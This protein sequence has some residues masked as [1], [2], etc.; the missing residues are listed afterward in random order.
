MDLAARE[1]EL[2]ALDAQLEAKQRE[3]VR[4]ADAT[5][6][7]QAARLDAI[8]GRGATG[9]DLGLGHQHEE[10]E[11]EQAQEYGDSGYAE[12]E[13]PASA[14]SREEKSDR[15]PPSQRLVP[16]KPARKRPGSR[17]RDGVA[18]ASPKSGDS[19]ENVLRNGNNNN[20]NNSNS[21]SD[22]KIRSTGGRME[23]RE[24]EGPHDDSSGSPREMGPDA[25]IRLQ[26]AKLKVLSDDLKKAEARIK[27]LANDS[28]SHKKKAKETLEENARLKKRVQSLEGSKDKD[29]AESTKLRNRVAELEQQLAT[30]TKELK[31][32][33]RAVKQVENEGNSKDVR[34]NR[35][36]EEIDRLKEKLRDADTAR[37]EDV[38]GSDAELKRIRGETKRLER[39]KAELLA[40]F[41]KQLKLI[42]VLKRQ[43]IHLEAA[44]ML[45]FTEEE[46]SRTLAAHQ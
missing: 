45:S 7:A 10:R 42:D 16:G 20:N 25:V 3:A 38:D 21:S 29:R 32:T 46:F 41:K 15:S 36:L 23:G 19:G 12:D 22:G 26:R 17:R 27:V 11:R 6:E 8:L 24:R 35:A 40:A 28:L 13:Y 33:G 9:D 37:R 44:Q 1:A 31:D 34:L 39:Q 2:L 14:R 5:L 18:L 30:V 4:E 43:K